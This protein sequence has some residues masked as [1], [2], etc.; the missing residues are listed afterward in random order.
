MNSLQSLVCVPHLLL[1]SFYELSALWQ[2]VV[3]KNSFW[4]LAFV[5]ISCAYHRVL[6][7]SRQD[8]HDICFPKWELQRGLQLYGFGL[9]AALSKYDAAMWVSYLFSYGVPCRMQLL[10]YRFEF[11][12]KKGIFLLHIDFQIKITKEKIAIVLRRFTRQT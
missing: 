4:L 9:V 11:H 5:R 3:G 1:K 6:F 10:F 12:A 8:L 7:R 2:V